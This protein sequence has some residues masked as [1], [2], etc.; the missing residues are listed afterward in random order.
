VQR[1]SSKFFFSLSVFIWGGCS[2]Q[3]ESLLG[4]HPKSFT[5]IKVQETSAEIKLPF[6]IWDL[7][8]GKSVEEKHGSA[9]H[10]SAHEAP[11]AAASD[12]GHGAAAAGGEHGAAPAD[13]HAGAGSSGPVD[14]W[15]SVTVQFAPLA[16]Y[17]EEK[18][19]GVLREPRMKIEFP[20]GGGRLNLSDYTTDQRGSF[21]FRIDALEDKD[22]S[23]HVYYVSGGRK[24]RIDDD[25][26]GTGCGKILNLKSFYL[27]QLKS[28]G[29]L[30]NT[31]RDRHLTL[32]A[33]TYV[34]AYKKEASLFLSQLTV[35]VD[36]P[37]KLLTCDGIQN[38]HS[39]TKDH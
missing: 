4:S 8:E 5:E 38:T 37:K 26:V 1:K 39:P 15:S 7:M 29:V 9:S 34:F 23:L 28:K 25:E 11:A 12:G 13:G 36:G 27:S 10:S 17:L 3:T 35:D 6:Q 21:Y 20:Q 2:H 18:N 16:V 24:R 32:L 14:F 30:V 22:E 19:P 31:T 33:G